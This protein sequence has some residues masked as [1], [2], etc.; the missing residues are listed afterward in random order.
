MTE[1]FDI[2]GK[3]IYRYQIRLLYLIELL[4]MELSGASEDLGNEERTVVAALLEARL[5]NW[6]T[7]SWGD[8]FYD[9][10]VR[11]LLVAVLE[12]WK[13]YDHRKEPSP[14]WWLWDV[15]FVKSLFSDHVKTEYL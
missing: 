3:K 2:F 7:H 11:S 13:K 5:T 15:D 4:H 1:E 12:D 9:N 10:S 14:N 8:S 6:L